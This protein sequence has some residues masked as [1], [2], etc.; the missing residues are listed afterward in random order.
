MERQTHRASLPSIDSEISELINEEESIVHEKKET[1]RINTRT[2]KKDTDLI[3]AAMKT[4]SAFANG[5]RE[6]TLLIGVSDDKKITGIER[7]GY[8]SQD[9]YNQTF[10]N[11]CRNIGPTK[12]LKS[13][14]TEYHEHD[15]KT[16]FVIRCPPKQKEIECVFYKKKPYRRTNSGSVEMDG[17]EL[18]E[19]IKKGKDDKQQP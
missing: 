11:L 1:L 17:P 14:K 3:D 13:I 10:D 2:E 12:Y 4:V 18:L 15:G 6:G 19:Y 9:V 16:I 5:D 7:D 8:T